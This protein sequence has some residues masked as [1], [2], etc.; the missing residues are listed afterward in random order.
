MA[1][2]GAGHDAYS[3]LEVSHTY[4]DQPQKE[5]SPSH[6]NTLPQ[7]LHPDGV[8]DQAPEYYDPQWSE[9]EKQYA[10]EHTEL[11]GRSERKRKCGLS[12]R[13]YWVLAVAVSLGILAAIVGGV[14]GGVLSSRKAEDSKSAG[15]Q[16]GVNG[17]SGSGGPGSVSTPGPAANATAI[18]LLDTSKVAAVNWTD[19]KRFSHYAVFSQDST[20]SIMVSLW[21]SQ[22]QTWSAVNI[23]DVLARSGNPVKAKAGTALSAVST[24]PPSWP[25][26]MDLYFL[27][28]SNNIMEVCS[29]DM[30]AKNW[31][32]GDLG[33]TPRTADEDSPLAS[34]WHRC[35]HGCSGMIYV[36]YLSNSVVQFLNG[37]DWTQT[38]PL[39]SA[40]QG[41]PLALFPFTGFDKDPSSYG[42]DPQL[43]LYYTQAGALGEIKLVPGTGFEGGLQPANDLSS[44]PPPQIA[45]A[46]F[47]YWFQSLLTILNDDGALYATWW[48][49]STWTGTRLLNVKGDH[50]TGFKA[51]AQHHERRIYA[52]VNGTIQEYRWE[53]TDPLTIISVG[54]VTLATDTAER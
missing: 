2:A 18:T 8:Y 23:S 12:S 46:P 3:T 54:K 15:A 48:D 45:G 24:G 36:A 35:H 40:D 1:S 9:R 38:R 37:S 16:T 28:P 13:K 52:V 22:N 41:S 27:T 34:V 47:D 25:F 19:A 30:D 53:Q 51:I 43:R 5:V 32:I 17:T 29:T 33:K 50:A 14:V 49:N 44:S 42:E 31:H 10:V 6:R 4:G 26:Q 39:T 7:A 21:D 20:N 11:G